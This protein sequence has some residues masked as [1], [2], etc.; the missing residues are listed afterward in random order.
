MLTFDSIFVLLIRFAILSFVLLGIG[1]LTLRFFKQPVEKI[2]LIQITLITLFA[3]TLL[4]VSNWKPTLNLAILPENPSTTP[5]VE[6]HREMPSMIWDSEPSDWKPAD[7]RA[8]KT[9]VPVL[10]Q[11][12]DLRSPVKKL[13][14]DVAAN[15]PTIPSSQKQPLSLSTNTKSQ[16]AG[17]AWPSLQQ[18]V[19]FLFLTGCLFQ[20]V[21][22]LFG[23]WCTRNLVQTA[24]S[25]DESRQIKTFVTLEQFATEHRVSIVVSDQIR[26]PIATGIIRPTIVLPLKMLETA[27][28]QQ[29][30]QALRHEWKHIEQNDLLTWYSLSLCQTL[31]WFQPC[32]WILRREL[33]VNQDLIADDAATVYQDRTDYAETLLTLANQQNTT[34]TGALTMAGTKSNLFRR[35][36]MLLNRHFPIAAM[37]RKRVVGAFSIA[38]VA[39]AVLMISI[40]LTSAA[41]LSPTPAESNLAQQDDKKKTDKPKATKPVTHTGKVL[42][43]GT[44]K[45]VKNAIVVIRRM[46]SKTWTEL[47][48]T[49]SLTN[50]RGEYSFK[51]PVEQLN[52]RYLYI[53]VD[54]KHKDKT[55]AP[56]HCGSYSYS[57]IKK[58]LKLGDKPWFTSLKMT[59]GTKISARLVDKAG[60][61]VAGAAI[62][63][64]SEG[65]GTANSRDFSRFSYS[66]TT[67]DANGRFEAVVTKEGIAR[68]TVVP[69]NHCMYAKDIGGKRGDLGDIELSDG[70]SVSGKVLDAR[71]KP[72]D[73]LWVNITRQGMTRS[74]KTDS[75]GKFKTRVLDAG[76]YTIQVQT[77][78]T[79]ALEKKEYANFKDDPPPAVFV[80]QVM[81]ITEATADKPI[82]IQAVPHIYIRGQGYDSKG[83]KR[84]IHLPDVLGTFDG[85]LAWMRSRKGKDTGSF[86]LM[87]PHGIERA[88][89]TFATSEH[90]ALLIQLGPGKKPTTERSFEYDKI[91]SDMLDVKVIRYVAPILQVNVVDENGK[92]VKGAAVGLVYEGESPPDPRLVGVK[93]HV[94]FE[95]QTDG[96]FRSSSLAPGRDF[97]V[98]AEKKGFKS[99]RKKFQLKEA[100]EKEI[101]IVMTPAKVRPEADSAKMKKDK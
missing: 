37:S 40:Q 36:D 75:G 8:Q 12:K 57:M 74:S 1:W 19:I 44:G 55:Y 28:K 50:E 45:P 67:S 29:V 22:L 96:K 49:E 27:D 65:P 95:K 23:F 85:Q 21:W 13:E 2:R 66:K 87:I 4:S 69:K 79:G 43:A 26:I 68:F 82:V 91:E 76:E 33:R 41:A 5:V 89:L 72:L 62:R 35:I 71:G 97:E 34:M 48:K 59:P 93:T 90:S 31:L 56:R 39:A 24:K 60:D 88:R 3:V 18:V 53:L 54:V 10:P 47:G 16:S 78:A 100:A 86:E 101:T 32:F 52:D 81:E 70:F 6:H 61:P 14:K 80:R 99:E 51:I 15:K 42:D 30:K 83:N 9:V 17:I 38:L 98:F 63:V 73:N 11:N 84:A 7:D 94:Y 64:N 46:S 77:K 20:C 25:L 58:N 92:P